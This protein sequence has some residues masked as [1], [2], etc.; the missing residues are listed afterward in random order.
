MN[1]T[2]F[3]HI[4]FQIL[5]RSFWYNFLSIVKDMALESFKVMFLLQIQKKYL[6]T[7]YSDLF[8]FLTSLNNFWLKFEVFL[9]KKAHIFIQFLW[10]SYIFES[11]VIQIWGCF[12][13]KSFSLEIVWL[14]F[15]IN[16]YTE[17]FLHILFKSFCFNPIFEL[18]HNYFMSFYYFS[19]PV[20][21]LNNKWIY[22]RIAFTD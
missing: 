3:S 7:I 13:H 5:L 19:T 22:L 15:F 18:H 4:L 21:A 8:S 17:S 10:C 9:Y 12:W 2:T 20:S 1:K 16:F 14:S 6:S 11:F